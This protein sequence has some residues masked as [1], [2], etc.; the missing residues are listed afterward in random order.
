MNFYLTA[1]QDDYTRPIVSV[2]TAC[3]ALLGTLGLAVA[4]EPMATQFGPLSPGDTFVYK[5]RGRGDTT[6]TYLR[7]ENGQLVFE[8]SFT[9]PKGA[10]KGEFVYTLDGNGVRWP[11]PDGEIRSANPNTGMLKFPMQVGTTWTHKYI[12]TIKNEPIHRTATMKVRKYKEIKT[13][14]GKFWAF[15]I[16]RRNQR[17]DRPLPA[18]ETY[19][20]APELG[21]IVKYQWE[22]EGI[23]GAYLELKSYSKKK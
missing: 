9:K 10:P 17:D 21:M 3:A 4:A 15:R 8:R 22:A 19:W 16:E 7:E 23:I 11:M 13:E 5:Y 18:Y 20:F 1:E 12:L 6:Q 2:F 14:A